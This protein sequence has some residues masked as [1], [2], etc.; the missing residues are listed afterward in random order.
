MTNSGSLA[1]LIPE[2]PGQTH[3]FFW[4]EIQALRLDGA[5]VKIISTRAPKT[6]NFH[7]FCSEIDE[8][9]YL[10]PLRY[11]TSI[12]FC[13]RNPRWFASTLAYCFSLKCSLKLRFRTLLFIPVAAN[14]A[15][16]CT[17][18]SIHHVHVHSSADASHITAL[19]SLC[20]K[21]TYSVC[22]HG[23]LNQYGD[24]H[25][26][27]LSSAKFIVTVTKPLQEEIYST[28]PQYPKDRVHVLAMGVDV[29]K[30]LPRKYPE[31]LE[32][33]FVITSVS[34]LV[35]VKGHKFALQALAQLP[36]EINFL[37][38]IVG[39]GELRSELEN[40][41]QTLG[42]NDR[43]TFLGFQKEGEVYN[44]LMNTDI[45][46]LTSFGFGEAAPV[47][48]ME[49]MAC[50]VASICSIIG[51]TKDM[52]T[53]QHDGMLVQQKNIHDIKQAVLF[54]LS[55]RKRLAT[56]GA[57]ARKTA[58]EKFSHKQS[59]STLLQYISQNQLA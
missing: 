36:S 8:T 3:I 47:A 41:V 16:Y 11:F 10:T 42:L 30:F 9:F 29:T 51:G 19:A 35:H 46:M 59:A 26:A 50:G 25:K 43:V 56:I 45:F 55:D 38:Q 54:L 52:I 31:I 32:K 21:F 12:L 24:N 13:L 18:H 48:I 6:R 4:R 23:N 57:N 17:E 7:E 14:L 58:E 22:I 40:E 33:Q 28:I 34:R 15:A 39:D 49:A 27:K 37:Y 44:T 5:S 20:K 2:F 1:V 53:N